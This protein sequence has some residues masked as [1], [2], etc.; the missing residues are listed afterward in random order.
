MVLYA[1]SYARKDMKRADDVKTAK[2]GG[3]VPLRRLVQRPFASFIT[4]GIYSKDLNEQSTVAAQAAA[5]AQVAQEHAAQASK[6]AV[7]ED[8]DQ[9]CSP[10]PSVAL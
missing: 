2:V 6:A 7:Q 8:Q 5:Q 1:A 9:V 4:S 3:N 10:E